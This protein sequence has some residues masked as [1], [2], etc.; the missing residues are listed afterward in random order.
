LCDRFFD[1][2]AVVTSKD[3]IKLNG[4][5]VDPWRLCNV[6][7]VEV[8]K[9][10]V[11]MIPIWL[12]CV[13]FYIPLTQHNTYTVYQALQMDRRLGKSRFHIPAGSFVVFNMLTLTL[14]IPIYDQLIVSRLRKITKHESGITMLQRMGIG[15]GISILGMV[16]SSLVEQHR[17]DI[18]LHK[19]TLGLTSGGGAIS[20]MS[21]LWLLPQLIL[22]GLCEAFNMIGQTEFFYHQFPENMRSIGMAVFCLGQA[23]SNY[24]SAALVNIIHKATGRNGSNNWLAEDLNEARLDL[25]YMT[26]G[27]IAVVN[28][29]YFIVCAK[30][31]QFNSTANS[32]EPEGVSEE[33]EERALSV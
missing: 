16:I 21:S 25:Y 17:R 28:L 9:C 29:M 31:Y 14:W 32:A 19:P 7:Q 22:F 11:R 18:A 8:V 10:V 6:Q 12:S 3:E 33:K 4:Q 23:V 13:L 2:A 15:I 26:V 24:I 5:A 20:S 27:G 1:K 30:L